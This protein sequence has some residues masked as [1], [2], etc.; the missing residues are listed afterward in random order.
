MWW[1]ANWAKYK[2]EF[3]SREQV[4]RVDGMGMQYRVVEL[5]RMG[6]GPK[7]CEFAC[8]LKKYSKLFA[9]LIVQFIC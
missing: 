1:R 7:K 3:L 8:W 2:N 6:R 5:M 4:E 9:Y